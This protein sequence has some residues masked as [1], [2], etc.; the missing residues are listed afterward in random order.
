M[1]Y[2]DPCTKETYTAF[3]ALNNGSKHVV[4]MRLPCFSKNDLDTLCL[5]SFGEVTAIILKLFFGICLSSESVER[6]LKRNPVI[7]ESLDRKTLILSNKGPGMSAL[8]MDIY[9][10]LTNNHRYPGFWAK[11]AICIS[12]L[13]GIYADIRRS[14]TQIIDISLS[15]DDD[16]GVVSAYYALKMG[17]PFGIIIYGSS[18]EENVWKLFRS[19]LSSSYCHKLAALLYAHDP[20]E[21]DRYVKACDCDLPFRMSDDCLSDLGKSIYTAVVSKERAEQLSIHVGNSFGIAVNSSLATSYG[22][23]QEYRS[24][25]GE[26]RMTLILS[27]ENKSSIKR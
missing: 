24:V 1:L 5:S 19:Q 8:I 20:K 14:G 27:E 3:Q 2:I 7:L 17:L 10:E 13:F 22:A 26:N 12:L 21:A 11:T 4:P 16:F 25:H 9:A 18:R 15:E 6:C 23:L